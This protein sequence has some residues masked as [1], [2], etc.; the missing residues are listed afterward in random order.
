MQP[1]STSWVF[2]MEIVRRGSVLSGTGG[3]VRSRGK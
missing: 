2:E 1:C 3:V